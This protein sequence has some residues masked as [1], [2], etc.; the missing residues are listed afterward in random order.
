MT[1]SSLK[2]MILLPLVCGVLVSE[3]FAAGLCLKPHLITRA[4]HC[5]FQFE[6]FVG[7]NG[8]TGEWISMEKITIDDISINGRSFPGVV[9]RNTSQARWNRRD[10]PAICRGYTMCAGASAESGRGSFYNI[11]TTCWNVN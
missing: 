5:E 1:F 4:G 11:D 7:T 2:T 9:A 10:G 3:S 6:A 8:C